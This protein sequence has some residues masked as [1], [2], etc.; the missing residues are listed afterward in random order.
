LASVLWR[1]P[2]VGPGRPHTHMGRIPPNV[3]THGSVDVAMRDLERVDGHHPGAALTE[4]RER[5]I[6]W[7]VRG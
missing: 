2:I 6:R 7:S 4:K 3:A 5:F 1:S